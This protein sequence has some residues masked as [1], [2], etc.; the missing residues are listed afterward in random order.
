MNELLSE[1]IGKPVCLLIEH[2]EEVGI[3]RG[4][5]QGFVCLDV[6]GNDD[7]IGPAGACVRA[8]FSLNVVK[9]LRT[10]GA[11]APDGRWP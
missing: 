4:V 10:H 11:P 9:A 5:G 7:D 2:H 3:L 1:L 6:L 8:F